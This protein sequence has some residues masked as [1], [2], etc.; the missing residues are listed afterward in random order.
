MRSVIFAERAMDVVYL[1]LVLLFGVAMFGLI[2]ACR[3]LGQRRER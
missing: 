3:R 1:I 2:A